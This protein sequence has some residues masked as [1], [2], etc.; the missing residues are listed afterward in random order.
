MM[1][2]TQL[3]QDLGVIGVPVQHPLVSVLG[4]V[5]VLLLLM[6][7]TDLEPYIFLG[8]RRWR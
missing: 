4:A 1:E 3:L 7:V 2:P 8:Q 5:E 6:N